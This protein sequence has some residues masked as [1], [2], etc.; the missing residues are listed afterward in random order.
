MYCATCDETGNWTGGIKPYGPLSMMPSAQ[1]LNY[2]QAIFEGMKA[3]WSAKDRI[4]LFRPDQNAARMKAGAARLCMQEVPKDIFIS[5]VTETVKA[6][7][8]FVSAI[9]IVCKNKQHCCHRIFV[10]GWKSVLTCDFNNEGPEI[11]H[12]T[13]ILRAAYVD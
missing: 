13:C 1:V 10:Y 11:F 6:N 12:S 4:V 3:Q 8:T 7:K 2:G 5:A 9:E